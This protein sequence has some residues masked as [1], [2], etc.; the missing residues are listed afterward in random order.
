MAI[1]EIDNRAPEYGRPYEKIKGV[2]RKKGL[3]LPGSGLLSTVSVAVVL[4]AAITS[5]SRM[6]RTISPTNRMISLMSRTISPTSRTIS[7]TSRIS[8]LTIPSRILSRIPGR[9]RIPLLTPLR[10]LIQ[11]PLRT[12]PT[13]IPMFPPTIRTPIRIQLPQRPKSLRSRFPVCVSG[14]IWDTLRWNTTS[15]PTTQRFSPPMQL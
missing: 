4:I 13:R 14:I 1:P 12:I 11:T 8:G 7:P 10:T 2:K 3:F 15:R 6:N 5:S 9:G